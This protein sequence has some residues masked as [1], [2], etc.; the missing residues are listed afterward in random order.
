M[1]ALAKSYLYRNTF[2]ETTGTKQYTIQVSKTYTLTWTETQSG[3]PDADGNPTTITVPRSD[4]QTVTKN[5]SIERKYSFWTIQNLEVYGIQKAIVSNYAL[6]SGTVTLEPNGYAPPTVSAAHDASLNA[7][8]IDPVYS[9]VTLPGQTISGGSSRPSVPNED[10]R[11]TAESAIGKIKVKNDSFIFNG[12]TI[13]DN[14]IVE[15]KAP[16]PGAI[17]APR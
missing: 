13:M 2:T 8:I 11:S 16:T 12:N 14:R 6:P 4:T 1:N 3:P 9:N 17:P 15:E 5:Y 7:H 10:W